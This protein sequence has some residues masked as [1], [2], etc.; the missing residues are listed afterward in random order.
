M[1]QNGSQVIFHQE[2]GPVSEWLFQFFPPI[3]YQFACPVHFQC[4]F[5]A[6]LVGSSAVSVQLLTYLDAVVW[7]DISSHFL[8]YYLFAAT[9][10]ITVDC[11]VSLGD[12]ASRTTTSAALFTRK[13]ILKRSKEKEAPACGLAVSPSLVNDPFI[14]GL[15]F[16]S[17]L[18][19]L[20]TLSNLNPRKNRYLTLEISTGK[21]PIYHQLS[22]LLV[23]F[24]LHLHPRKTIRW[25]FEWALKHGSTFYFGMRRLIIITKKSYLNIIRC[26]SNGHTTM[27]SIKSWHFTGKIHCEGIRIHRSDKRYSWNFPA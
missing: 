1:F 23:P 9:S 2:F 22:L 19:L 3:L 6:F 25:Y 5:S 17:C 14:G 27:A 13:S 4:I 18:V 20:Q 21:Y 26:Y 12:A 15:F 16:L 11:A 10:K 8:Y 24:L 7:P